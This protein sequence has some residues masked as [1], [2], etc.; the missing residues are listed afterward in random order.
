MR[1]PLQTSTNRLNTEQRQQKQEL[2]QG[3]RRV[4]AKAKDHHKS[5]TSKKKSIWRETVPPFFSPPPSQSRSQNAKAAA[6]AKASRR[7]ERGRAANDVD[8]DSKVFCNKTVSRAKLVHHSSG[9]IEAHRVDTLSQLTEGESRSL[10]VHAIRD[11]MSVLSA[12]SVVVVQSHSID[13]EN[14]QLSTSFRTYIG[15]GID[16]EEEE[17]ERGS[18]DMCAET[19]PTAR[20]PRAHS[21][22][23][24]SSINL[25][26]GLSPRLVAL[27]SNL[28]ARHDS[29]EV[30]AHELS[31][32]TQNFVESHHDHMAARAA[33]PSRS[34]KVEDAIPPNAL[35]S[36]VPMDLSRL[37]VSDM[38]EMDEASPA[39]AN[40]NEQQ[41]SSYSRSSANVKGS[42][43]KKILKTERRI[44]RVQDRLDAAERRAR[45]VP[46]LEAKIRVLDNKLKESKKWR[47]EA[48]IY[49]RMVK[50]LQE[51]VKATE[52]SALHSHSVVLENM[53]RAFT[54]EN[55]QNHHHQQQQQ[56]LGLE[57]FPVQASQLSQMSHLSQMGSPAPLSRYRSTPAAT[58]AD[59]D[60]LT[61]KSRSRSNRCLEEFL[62]AEE[63]ELGWGMIFQE[64]Y[65]RMDRKVKEYDVRLNLGV[66]CGAA[67]LSVGACSLLWS[68]LISSRSSRRARS[69]ILY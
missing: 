28:T 30:S 16:G 62:S 39:P 20:S 57:S 15:N 46:E 60:A 19:A 1:E 42:V 7:Q 31:Q 29:N 5:S 52:A 10:N 53:A 26:S 6:A 56:G 33:T 69:K 22:S 23:G 34:V 65:D 50:S 11:D 49:K 64:F 59:H 27:Q 17:G 40:E 13:K 43:G 67:G 21:L 51:K 44:L 48:V 24:S 37:E 38:Q 41:Q 2:V 32:V 54:M 45:E 9:K 47:D 3:K 4:M 14:E 35:K 12:D 61:P 63:Q 18:H 68:S 8:E 25:C 58:G 66:I 36:F 55:Q